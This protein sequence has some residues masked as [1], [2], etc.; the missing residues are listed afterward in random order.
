[1][2]SF[3]KKSLS[4]LALSLTGA[5]ACGSFVGCGGDDDDTTGPTPDG[6]GKLDSSTGGDSGGKNDG[7]TGGD[8]GPTD[9]G[10]GSD[11]ADTGPI[12][13]GPQYFRTGS[14][15]LTQT[16]T[17]A[18]T[19]SVSGFASFAQV[20]EGTAGSTTCTTSAVNAA[21]SLTVCTA[22]V[23]VDAGDAGDA[24]DAAVDAAVPEAP[25]A[26]VITLTDTTTAFPAAITLTPNSTTGLYAPF[27]AS[28]KQFAGAD[29]IG[30]TAGGGTVGAFTNTVTAPADLTSTTPALSSTTFSFPA[31]S[32][33]SDLAV[34]WVGATQGSSVTVTLLDTPKPATG[35]SKTLS[36]KFDGFGGSGTVP[37]TG[38]LAKLDHIDGTNF[39]GYLSITPSTSSTTWGTV[40]GVDAGETPDASNQDFLVTTTVTA[41]AVSGSATT[42]D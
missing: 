9:G 39:T 19:Y 27:S 21:C 13:A 37:S 17:S 34:S 16:K 5:V 35:A 33:G 12:D 23:A 30:F 25:Q 36:C 11:A 22:P 40:N 20:L 42:S 6:G 8:S 14:V 32:R 18:L 29:S 26:G 4:I 41:T 15:S 2:K 7:S 28:A 38:G 3:T 24:G 31:F 1:M 10:P